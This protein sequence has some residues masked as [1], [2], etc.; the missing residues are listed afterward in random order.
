MLSSHRRFHARDMEYIQD[1][2][3]TQVVSICPS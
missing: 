2:R 1:G 3:V